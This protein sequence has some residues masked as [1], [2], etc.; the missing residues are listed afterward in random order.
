MRSGSRRTVP[1]SSARSLLADSRRPPQP[2]PSPNRPGTTPPI[3]PRANLTTAPRIVTPR[4]TPTRPTD[5][6]ARIPGTPSP[7]PETYRLSRPSI[8]SAPAIDL[9]PYLS[10]HYNTSTPT[11]IVNNGHQIQVQFP[12]DNP[13]DTITVGG[14]VFHLAQFHYHDPSEHTI[15]HH[16]YT[17]EEHFVNTSASGAEAVVG[18][19]LQLGAHNDALQ[20]ILDAAT[21][22][23]R[24]PAARRPTLPRSISPAFFL[25]TSPAGFT[26]VRSPRLLSR[27]R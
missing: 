20:P 24:N 27:R 2:S 14:Q 3:P 22:I 21:T 8:S 13:T 5:P 23:W 26:P 4:G 16:G 25:P 19:F 1:T 6:S 7:R 9:S 12:A 10:I 17:M 18:V 11:A 15:R